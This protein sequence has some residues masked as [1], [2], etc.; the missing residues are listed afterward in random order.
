MGLASAGLLVVMFTLISTSLPAT[1]TNDLSSLLNNSDCA[2]SMLAI[3]ADVV[4][5]GAGGGVGAGG[6]GTGAGAGAAGGVAGVVGTPATG[7]VGV[8]AVVG[9]GAGAMSAELP[10]PPQA[11]SAQRHNMACESA[12]LAVWVVEFFK[13][14]MGFLGSAIGLIRVNLSLLWSEETQSLVFSSILARYKDK[15]QKRNEH[16]CYLFYSCLSKL[17]GLYIR[18]GK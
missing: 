17:H 11:A 10:P 16:K 13:V 6:A 4:A 15:C 12:M 1:S 8:A 7:T 3:T 14:G 18:K 5:L 9:L 2:S